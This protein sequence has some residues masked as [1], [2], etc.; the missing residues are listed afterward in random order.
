MSAQERTSVL[1]VGGGLVGLS[2]ALF[3]R[4]HGVDCVLVER[5]EKAS[6]LPRSRGVHTR[7]VE[8]F[9]QIGIEDQVQ[10][11][12]RSALKAG[13]FGGARSGATMADAEPLTMAMVRPG[14]DPSPSNFCFCPQVLLEPLLAELARERGARLRFGATVDGLEIGP[15][16][17][18]ATIGGEQIRA[19]YVIAADG[20]GSPIRER[21][22][23]GGWTL[24]PTHHYVNVFVRADLTELVADGRTFSQCEFAN[25][26]VRGLILSKNNTDEWSFHLEYDPATQ[27][28]ADFPPE[29]C[30]ELVRAAVGRPDVHVQ[31]SA[32]STW[33]TGVLVADEYRRGRILLAGDA[34]HR[35]A[36]WG[37]FGAN[38]GIADVHNLAWKLAAVL[39][40]R[41][42]PDL[43]DTY[44]Q[45]RRPR[46]LLAANQARLRTDFHARYGIATA[47]NQHDLARQVDLGAIMTRYRYVSAAAPDDGSQGEWVEQLLGQV[48]TR[49]PHV[50]ITNGAVQASTLDFCG[51]GFTVLGG[52][53]A[54]GL[55]D[56]ATR[57]G[58]ETGFPVTAFR[59]GPDG[60][61]I[62]VDQDWARANSL[63]PDEALLVRPDGHIAAKLSSGSGPAELTSLLRRATCAT[64]EIRS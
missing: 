48:G 40:G 8:M 53:D 27:T 60:D 11:V 23:I 30:V 44:G 56:A 55:G 24:P 58:A 5:R 13:A 22:G 6:V 46:A 9:R 52:P 47:D 54:R 39:A 64:E 3:L 62:G 26:A 18:T 34:V 29:R 28:L 31:V 7:T 20:A 19:D 57:A 25:E 33:D 35:H 43:L 16:V 59:I 21:L 12:A 14:G 17:V 2:A 49:L 41:S 32:V 4:Y 38:T 51:P 63:R 37:G 36:P 1:I 42:G 15:D 61:C 50:W 10:E 45:E